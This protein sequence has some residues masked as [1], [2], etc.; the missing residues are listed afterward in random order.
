M[1]PR[2][3]TGESSRRARRRAG[4]CL[5]ALLASVGACVSVPSADPLQFAVD[6]AELDAPA[7]ERAIERAAAT[8][9]DDPDLHLLIVGHADDR[10]A[11]RLE[12]LGQRRPD[13]PARPRDRH[14]HPGRVANFGV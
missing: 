14:A 11:A 2:C 4:V 12:G 13:Q 7:D 5:L 3:C 9:R 6:D 10:V 8:L 1:T